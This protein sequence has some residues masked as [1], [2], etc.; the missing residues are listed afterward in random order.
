MA[1]APGSNKKSMGS[2]RGKAGLVAKAGKRRP[3]HIASFKDSYG[4]RQWRAA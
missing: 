1:K 2:V 3:P 4:K